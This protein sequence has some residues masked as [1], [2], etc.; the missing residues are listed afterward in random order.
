MLRWCE[1]RT[2]APS[3]KVTLPGGVLEP[4]AVATTVAVKVTFWPWLD[5]LSE[6]VTVVVVAGG[7]NSYA[8]MSTVPLIMRLKPVPR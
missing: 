5:G 7:W 4:D 2:V 8:P 1:P 6:V 3:R